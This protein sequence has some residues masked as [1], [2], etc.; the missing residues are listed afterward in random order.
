LIRRR[1]ILLKRRKTNYNL[2]KV[3]GDKERI[4]IRR[5]AEHRGLIPNLM[6][7]TIITMALR[8]IGPA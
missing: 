2:T 3:I 6:L 8:G 4:I 7:I 5:V 1:R